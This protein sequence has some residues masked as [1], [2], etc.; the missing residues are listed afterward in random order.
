MILFF[1]KNMAKAYK[2]RGIKVPDNFIPCVLARGSFHFPWTLFCPDTFGSELRRMYIYQ[3]IQQVAPLIS[4]KNVENTL[5]RDIQIKNMF[6][7]I[8]HA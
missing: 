4:Q 1:F 7:R 8:L 5:I 2:N 3:S 6:T